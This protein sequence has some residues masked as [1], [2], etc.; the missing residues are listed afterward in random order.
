MCQQPRAPTAGRRRSQDS[1][2]AQQ[3]PG[4]PVQGRA[5]RRGRRRSQR[6]CNSARRPQCQPVAPPPQLPAARR[7]RGGRLAAGWQRRRAWRGRCRGVGA[8]GPGWLAVAACRRLRLPAPPGDAPWNRNRLGSKHMHEWCATW[9]MLFKSLRC[10]RPT[11]PDWIDSGLLRRCQPGQCPGSVSARMSHRHSGM[12]APVAP[13]PHLNLKSSPPNPTSVSW[14]LLK[15]RQYEAHCMQQS[16]SVKGAHVLCSAPFQGALVGRELPTSARL[17]S[18]SSRR[19]CKARQKGARERSCRATWLKGHLPPK[20]QVT[21]SDTTTGNPG[22]QPLPAGPA[23]SCLT[24]CC[25]PCFR[26]KRALS[27]HA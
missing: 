19:S 5:P 24:H 18:H 11:R 15:Q 26:Q 22:L 27:Q 16:G 7:S 3:Q 21:D 20:R 12:L 4:K 8:G 17:R 13:P 14:R 9:H 6:L 1:R 10:Q 23:R 25:W 2:Q